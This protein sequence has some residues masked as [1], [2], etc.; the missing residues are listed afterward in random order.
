MGVLSAPILRRVHPLYAGDVLGPV[1]NLAQQG[2]LPVD[3]VD[4]T[5]PGVPAV[6]YG[7]ILMLALYLMPNGAAEP[8]KSHCRPY[9]AGL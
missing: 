3:D 6:V 8:G 5:T 2:Q 1:V 4:P 7:V 9:K